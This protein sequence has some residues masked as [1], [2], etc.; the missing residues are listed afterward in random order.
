VVRRF[1]GGQQGCTHTDQIRDVDS[2]PEK[3]GGGATWTRCWSSLE[4]HLSGDAREEA[5]VGTAQMTYQT[6]ANN[7][8]GALRGSGSSSA[9]KAPNLVNLGDT[10]IRPEA[11]AALVACIG[12]GVFCSLGSA[13]LHITREH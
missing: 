12:G 11:Y 4:N 5:E 10:L 2:S 1:L 9:K 6:A 8:A 7:R 3:T 13:P